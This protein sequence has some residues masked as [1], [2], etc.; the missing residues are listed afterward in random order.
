MPRYRPPTAGTIRKRLLGLRGSGSVHWDTA[1]F[2]RKVQAEVAAVEPV[3]RSLAKRH[4]LREVSPGR[5]AFNSS[6]AE[7]LLKLSEERA[8]IS[9]SSEL[10]ARRIKMPVEE[11][12]NQLPTLVQRG[13][14]GASGTPEKPIYTLL[15]SGQRRARLRPA[16]QGI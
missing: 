14:L 11:V 8:T 1:A 15:L 7:R 16:T 4:V 2:A 13:I 5:Y 10:I 12:R 9:G 6:V 3:M